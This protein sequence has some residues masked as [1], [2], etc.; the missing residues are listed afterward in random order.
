MEPQDLYFKDALDFFDEFQ[1]IFKYP[2]T[3]ILIKKSLDSIPND[4]LKALRKLNYNELNNF[5]LGKFTKPE[6]PPS[7]LSFIRQCKKLNTLS[8]APKI[9]NLKPSSL[10]SNLRHGLTSKKQ[11]EV[12]HLVNFIHEKCKAEKIHTI[13]DFGSGLGYICQALNHL[14]GY[15]VVGLESN[16]E[17]YNNACTRQLEL[18]PD[19]SND[20][21]YLHC[22]VN[23]ENFEENIQLLK[24]HISNPD[25]KICMIGLH[26][27]GDLAVASAFAFRSIQQ[28]K[29]LIMMS[30]CYHKL[31]MF[32]NK[33]KYFGISSSFRHAMKNHNCKINLNST[34]DERHE[35]M[36][37]FNRP[38]MR[39][40]CQESARRWEEMSDHD[41]Q[42]HA[43]CVLSRAVLELFV[44]E[45]D[46]TLKKTVKKATRK[47]QCVNF[48][49]YLTDTL[50]R[51]IFNDENAS[52]N[53][54]LIDKLRKKWDEN[55]DK[56]D[57]IE[58]FT[59]LQ[60]LL[61]APAESL[62][63]EDRHDKTKK[64][65]NA[66][67]VPIFDPTISP[68]CQAIVARVED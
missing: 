65:I 39:L 67:I 3:Q 68:R 8:Q 1:W 27:C 57:D 38:F 47:S 36:D 14:F 59:A 10:P 19:S 46:I 35:I 48:D 12:S 17:I 21:T 11:H 43:F 5:V 20:V 41:H 64:K 42:Q 37:I 29:L 53:E 25:E 31:E 24:H 13:V 49:T 50:Q 54:E 45:N 33:M 60:V 32:E 63:L 30:C 55:K 51:Y 44:H 16:R 22:Q 9:S 66:V 56:L 40:A 23:F 7:L 34:T 26:S 52:K 15:R 6:W 2:V 18:F 62:V 58:I 61:Q 28:S 4:W